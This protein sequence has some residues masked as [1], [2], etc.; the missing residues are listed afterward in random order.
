MTYATINT[1]LASISDANIPDE[2]ASTA[3]FTR[4]QDELGD[5][6]PKSEG[7]SQDSVKYP[8]CNMAEQRYPQRRSS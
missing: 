2:Y 5:R 3:W 7:E 1:N 4:L 6:V 8:T